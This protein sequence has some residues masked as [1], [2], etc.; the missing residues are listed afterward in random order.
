MDLSDDDGLAG[1][2]VLV[3]SPL[4]TG[5]GV[6]IN[7]AGQ[8]L[9]NWHLVRGLDSVAIAFKRPGEAQVATSDLRRARVLR[10][11]KYPDLALLAVQGG[12]PVR[13]AR[14]V[15]DKAGSAKAARGVRLHTLHLADSGAWQSSVVKVERVRG[16]SSWYSGRRVLHRATVI[17]A[18]IE[19]PSGLSGAPLF[20]EHGEIAGMTTL[21]KAEKNQLIAV[22]DQ[23]LRRFLDPPR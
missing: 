15:D 1:A 7:E 9:T 14:I 2:V 10:H 22:S 20:N 23:T 18:D 5:A 21:V 6:V 16:S 3:I 8:V 13:A 4:G 19:G 17:R 12:S 11:S